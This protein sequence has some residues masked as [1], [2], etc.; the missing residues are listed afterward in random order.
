MS[1]L[2]S[3]ISIAVLTAVDQVI[4]FVVERYLQPIGSAEFINGFIMFATR[5]RRLARFRRARP[6]FQ[7]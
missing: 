6:C 1:V 2:I 4:K 3:F 5:E 7:S